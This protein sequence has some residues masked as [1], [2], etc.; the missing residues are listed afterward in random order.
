MG[1]SAPQPPA[2]PDPTVVAGAQ[3]ASDEATANYQSHL[4]N[5]NTVSPYGTV[6]N[7]YDPTANQWTQTTALSAPEQSL[8]DQST[9][10][11]NAALGVA[12]QQIGRVSTALDTPL[13]PPTLQNSVGPQGSIASGY[14]PGGQIQ[15]GFNQGSPIATGYSAGGP[16]QSGYAGGGQ[17]ATGYDTGGGV[18][19]QFNTGPALQTSVQPGQIGAQAAPAPQANGSVG[20]IQGRFSGADPAF[21]ADGSLATTPQGA[22]AQGGGGSIQGQI[23]TQNVGQAVNQ[24]I[25]SQYGA[26]Q[27]LLAPQQQQAA[28]HQNAQ[29]VAQGL[30]PNDAAYQNSQTLFNNAQ[31]QQNAQTAAAAVAAGNTEQNTLFGQQATQGQFANQAQAQQYGQDLSSGQFADT[32][33]GQQFAQNQAAA[34]FGNTAQQQ[35]NTQN[36]QQAAFGNAAQQQATAQS[37]A[38]AQFGN[39][40]QQQANAQNA[41]QATFGNTAAGQQYA[42]NEGA[43]QFANTAQQQQDS[44][45]A[46]QAGFGNTAQQQAYG[47][48]QTNASLY[49]TAAQQGFQNTAYSQ[50]QP[51]NE[52]D[53]LLSSGQVQSPTA[54]QFGQTAVAP[55]DVT[56]AYALQ[57]QQLNNNYQAQVANQNAGLSGLFNL[58]SAALSFL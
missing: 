11:S 19:S 31:A 15:T 14:D 45:N 33:A 29:L 20:G 23:G 37:A 17:I 47:Q 8:F 2:A 38:A 13:T 43:S 41:A 22:P 7:Q 6:T 57:Q 28:E 49:N 53:A 51:I 54:G 39:T 5:G 56:G 35:V 9:Q 55:T 24:T 50:Q 27:G 48:A 42:Q 3:T 58:G 26:M 52:L 46:A 12:N 32:A 36:Q 10:A 21:N 25:Q 30:N 16:I 4:N 40:A 44:Q 34:A 1:K 18:Q